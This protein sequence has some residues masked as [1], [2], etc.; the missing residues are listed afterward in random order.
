M[1]HLCKRTVWV[2]HDTLHPAVQTNS[3]NCVLCVQK[4]TPQAGIKLE[5]EENKWFS[6]SENNCHVCCDRWTRWRTTVQIR[7]DFKKCNRLWCLFCLSSFSLKWWRIQKVWTSG[8]ANGGR[9]RY[10]D[11]ARPKE[12]ANFCDLFVESY[13]LPEPCIFWLLCFAC[14]IRRRFAN[15]E[16]TTAQ[17]CRNIFLGLSNLSCHSAVWTLGHDVWLHAIIRSY[18]PFYYVTSL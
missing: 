5:N 3:G 16:K 13:F 17:E 15:Y 9:A 4:S 6:L 7:C 14:N 8:S 2:A 18:S 11:K 12:E 10:L 1:C